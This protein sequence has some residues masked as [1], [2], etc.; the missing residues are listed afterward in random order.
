[1]IAPFKLALVQMLV[2]PGEA[3]HNL[4]RALVYA[5]QAAAAGAR[6]VLLPEALPYGWT[7]PSGP[8]QAPSIAGGC[9]AEK[10]RGTARARSIYICAGI[11]EREESR[12]FN[13]AI[14][15]D[16]EG[17]IILHHRKLNELD[18][19][20]SC[21]SLGDRL[22]VA[23]TSFGRMGVMICADA[24]ATGQ[25]I[26]RTLGYMGARVILSPCAWAVP[27]DHDNARTPYGQ[28]W[29]DNYRPVA[30]DFRLW[31][32]GCSNVGPIPR[33]PWAGRKCIGSSLVVDPRGQKRLQ[34]SYGE[35]AEEILYLDIAPEPA[36]A[37][38]TQWEECWNA[39]SASA[40]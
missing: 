30:R 14:L 29:M 31:I 27:P 23:E 19:A 8:E 12:V 38:G 20:H 26:A 35:A 24:F 37:Q 21:Y 13:S 25:V 36:P 40:V 16:P 7:D 32:A 2:K 9:V 6:V 5:T 39:N 33:G 34:G 28:L 10:L 15:I 11:V 22:A 17:K 4:D 1:M 3:R 18:I